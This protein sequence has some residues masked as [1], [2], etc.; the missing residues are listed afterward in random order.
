MIFA[1]S[2][3]VPLVIEYLSDIDVLT[4]FIVCGKEVKH[5]IRQYDLKQTMHQHRVEVLCLTLPGSYLPMYVVSM[6]D[7]YDLETL[8]NHPH[9]KRIYFGTRYNYVI[10]PNIIP[11]TVT[12]I[13]FGANFNHPIRQGCLPNSLTHLV[14][15]HDFNQRLIAGSIPESVQVIEFGWKFNQP[16]DAGVLSDHVTI[17][18]LRPNM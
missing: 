18:G 11:N 13:H 6:K 15:G 4:K 17:V 10:P 5:A 7:V 3:V 14:F 8:S 2:F 1:Y 16:I 9:L 12:E